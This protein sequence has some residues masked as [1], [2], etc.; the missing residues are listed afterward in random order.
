MLCL[1]ELA[2]NSVLHSASRKP[3]GVFTMRAEIRHGDY[4]RIEVRDEGGA[5]NK[6]PGPEGRAHGL[7]IV[8][9]LAD[10]SGVDGDALTGWIA[11]ARFAWPGRATAPETLDG[12]A[13][14]DAPCPERRGR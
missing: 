9:T 1:S 11:W 4:V 2:G 12:R 8:R 13:R 3:G 5:W 14:V 6:R 7:A 10:E